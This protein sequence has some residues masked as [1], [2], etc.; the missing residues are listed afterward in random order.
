LEVKFFGDVRDIKVQP[1]YNELQCLK[2]VLILGLYHS[3]SQD[4]KALLKTKQNK[5]TNKQKDFIYLF[6]FNN[7]STI[8]YDWYKIYIVLNIKNLKTFK[9]GGS[10]T[11]VYL[12][13]KTDSNP[14]NK[15]K[16]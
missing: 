12:R 2:F 4:F 16:F 9:Y 15:M 14:R 8:F 10:F 7:M 3:K 13:G 5:Q 6:S 11:C 1:Y